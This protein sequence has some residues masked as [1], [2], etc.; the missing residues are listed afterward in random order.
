M[1]MNKRAEHAQTVTELA[2]ESALEF[3]R[4]NQG[5]EFNA[6]CS[7]VTQADERIGA[8]VRDYLTEHFPDHGIFDE[9]HGANGVDKICRDH[10]GIFDT[11]M[12]SDPTRRLSYD[13]YPH[14]LLMAGHADAVVDYD[15]LPYD[16]LPVSALVEVTGGIMTGNKLD[17]TSDDRVISAATPQLHTEMFDL[18]NG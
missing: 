5:V 3:F 14:A 4:G 11:A 6:D 12:Q 7:L 1:T 17:L 18:V 13:C 2:C 10:T 15:L 9:E 16:D 8:E